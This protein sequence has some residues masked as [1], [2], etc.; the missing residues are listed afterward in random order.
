M[1]DRAR[2]YAA[3]GWPVFPLIPGQKKPL[4][5]S[6]HPPGHGCKGECGALGHGLYDATL[7]D[8]LI[9]AW[10]GE[11]GGAIDANIGIRTGVACWV[12][13][14][15]C[16]APKGGGLTGPEMVALLE[17]EHGSLPVTLSVRTPGGGEHRF[18]RLPPDRI[19]PNRTTIHAPDGRKT[20]LDVRGA[21]GY[22]VAE[23]STVDGKPY[24][25][26]VR[27]TMAFAPRWLLDVVAPPKRDRAQPTA[28]ITSSAGERAT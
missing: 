22:V 7:D 18:F 17:A 15:D 27:A 11:D 3:H 19:I 21:G 1:L 16:K 4:I 20:S 9:A 6:A 13:D 5:K 12:L 28:K 10:W 8:A 23:P 25:V 24:A 26:L 2:K 14:I